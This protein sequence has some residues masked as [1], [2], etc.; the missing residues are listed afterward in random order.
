[1]R[2]NTAN[3]Q[4]LFVVLPFLLIVIMQV[5][6]SAFSLY[7]VS[8][9]RAYVAGEGLWSKAQKDSIYYLTRY[10]QTGADHDF[11]RYQQAIAIQLGDH[12]ARLALDRSP[13]ISTPRAKASSTAA[14]IPTTLKTSSAPICGSAMSAIWRRPSTIGE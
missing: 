4:L 3:R 8:T 6:L 12:Q 7:V 1:M 9:A 11:Q 10:A 5:A 2:P 14:T 13:P